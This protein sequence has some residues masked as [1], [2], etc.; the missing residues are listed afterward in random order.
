MTTYVSNIPPPPKR[1]IFKNRVEFDK[2]FRKWYE[3]IEEQINQF[4]DEYWDK[5]E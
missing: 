4:N 2:K 3:G 5:N 1:E